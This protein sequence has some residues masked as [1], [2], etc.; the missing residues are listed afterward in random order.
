MSDAANA[1]SVPSWKYIEYP[2]Y[3]VMSIRPPDDYYAADTQS[4]RREMHHT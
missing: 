4:C 2:T 3:E 1:K